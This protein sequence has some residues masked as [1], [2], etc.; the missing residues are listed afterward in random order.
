MVVVNNRSS[1]FHHLLRLQS[2]ATTDHQLVRLAFSSTK[3]R[4]KR[5]PSV[6]ATAL[7]NVAGATAD[8]HRDIALT[9]R[10]DLAMRFPHREGGQ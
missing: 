9:T 5:E 7:F 3:L 10:A 4:K 2:G 6:A 8:I 1:A